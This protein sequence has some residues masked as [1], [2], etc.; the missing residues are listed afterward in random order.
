MENP[1]QETAKQSLRVAELV[2]L[3][4]KPALFTPGKP[5]FWADPHISQQ[6]LATH[7][8]PDLDAAS[9]KPETIETTVAWIEDILGLTAGDTVLDLGCGPGLYAARLAERRLDVTGVEISPR[10]IAYAERYAQNHGLS[11]EY[12]CQNYLELTD[13]NRFDAVLLI[14]GD[15]CTFNPQDRRRLLNNVHRALRPGGHFVFDISTRQHRALAGVNNGWYASQ[16]GFW[17]PV[18][19]LVLEQGFD[20]PDEKVWLDQYI[21]IEE[22]GEMAVYRNWFQ[23]FDPEMITAELASGGFVVQSLWA[24]LAGK[25]FHT[26][27]EWIGLVA[28]PTEN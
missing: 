11:I 2:K 5:L 16:D 27:S 4:A 7:L 14:F 1:K 20:Y 21:V 13:V 24:D 15:Y 23:D 28:K 17:R 12:R 19:H 22:N 18:P 6:M 25:T 3:L 10:S 8:D 26:E 9:R